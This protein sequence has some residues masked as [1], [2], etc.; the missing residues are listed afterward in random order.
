MNKTSNCCSGSGS[1]AGPDAEVGPIVAGAAARVAAMPDPTLEAA[2]WR[3]NYAA[4]PYVQQGSSFDDYGPAYAFAVSAYGRHPGQSFDEAEPAMAG[5]WTTDRGASAL[6]WEHAK[7]AASDAWQRLN[8]LF[9]SK[10]Q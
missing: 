1:G 5:E 4:R 6:S 10:G 2:Y 7:Q 8:A 9:Q 3:E